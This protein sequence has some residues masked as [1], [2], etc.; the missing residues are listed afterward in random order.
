[1]DADEGNYAG[2]G[3]NHRLSIAKNESEDQFFYT[4]TD[5]RT[6]EP[7][8]KNTAPDI[9]GF[10]RHIGGGETFSTCFTEGTLYET[11]YYFTFGAE[12]AI[13]NPDND[14]YSVP[15]MTS[16]SPAE[17]AGNAAGDPIS[18]NYVTGIE[19][20]L[21][22]PFSSVNQLNHL[23]GVEVSQNQPNPF[24]GI[25][26]IEIKTQKASQINVEVTN[27]MGQTVYTFNAGTNNGT[28]KIILSAENLEAG[29]YFYT[30]RVGEESVTK[31]MIIE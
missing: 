22:N 27:L 15:Y 16:V 4:W 26:T 14:N 24:T 23:S 29:V 8:L 10:T 21:I 31:K 3:W 20:P 6:T 5:T 2:N 18:I 1:M 7:D 17:F 30:V 25:T 19:F 11:F 28:Q 9:F 12:Y 13:Y